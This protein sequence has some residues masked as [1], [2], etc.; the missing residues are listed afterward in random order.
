MKPVRAMAKT[1]KNTLGG[2]ILST[3]RFAIGAVKNPS[4]A[5]AEPMMPKVTGEYS[6]RR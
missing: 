3:M 5:M 2:V 4:P 1:E 6:M